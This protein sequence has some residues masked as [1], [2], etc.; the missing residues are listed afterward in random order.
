[1]PVPQLGVRV[2]A[3]DTRWSFTNFRC[4]LDIYVTIIADA[5]KKE[6]FFPLEGD[7]FQWKIS[8]SLKHVQSNRFWSKSVV[9]NSFMHTF[10]TRFDIVRIRKYRW[11]RKQL[12]GCWDRSVKIEK[13]EDI[14]QP[15]LLEKQFRRLFL[16]FIVLIMRLRGSLLIRFLF[17]DE[18][19]PKWNHYYWRINRIS[20]EISFE[21]IF[22]IVNALFFDIVPDNWSSQFSYVL[23]TQ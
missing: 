6:A 12:K 18:I 15:F 16:H 5:S 20:V 3:F 23:M 17:L 2:S 10:Q 14:F 19:F 11:S 8:L 22:F 13:F 7:S 1:M 9:F 4:Q 21:I